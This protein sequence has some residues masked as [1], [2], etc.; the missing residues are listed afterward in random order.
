MLKMTAVLP[1]ADVLLLVASVG[2]VVAAASAVAVG[3][4][5]DAVDCAECVEHEIV[6]DSYDYAEYEI[7]G[8][9]PEDA[10]EDALEGA[11]WMLLVFV[12]DDDFDSDSNAHDV[13]S[14]NGPFVVVAVVVVKELEIGPVA[15]SVV[16]GH[17]FEEY[18]G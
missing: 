11:D 6:D 12:D 16:D 2:I 1:S 8:I 17:N 13:C 3:V 9:P 10:L 15:L 14:V 7:A 18:A 4:V 5:A